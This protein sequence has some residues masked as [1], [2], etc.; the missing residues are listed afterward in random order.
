MDRRYWR[1]GF[2]VRRK[3]VDKLYEAWKWGLRAAG[4]QVIETSCLELTA[5]AV[6]GA[7]AASMKLEHTTL[8]RY[9]TPHIPPFDPDIHV[10]NLARLKDCGIGVER[11]QKLVK[12]LGTFYAVLTAPRAK[13]HSIIGMAVTKKLWETLGRVE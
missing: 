5:R 1:P 4:V 3:G 8:R 13:L 6:A 12:Q 11:A 10:D 2:A 9:V 7:Y